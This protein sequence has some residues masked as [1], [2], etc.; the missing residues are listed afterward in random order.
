MGKGY[1]KT[2]EKWDTDTKW[3]RKYGKESNEQ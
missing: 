1:I 3:K 2:V